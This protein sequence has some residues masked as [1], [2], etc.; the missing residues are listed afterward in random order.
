MI[1]EDLEIGS[2]LGMGMRNIASVKSKGKSGLTPCTMKY[3]KS[4]V[5]LRMVMHSAQNTE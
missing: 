2:V 1:R 3:G 4:L 5:D